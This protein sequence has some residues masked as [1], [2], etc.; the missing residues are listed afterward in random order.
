MTWVCT[1][2]VTKPLLMLT[3]NG[4]EQAYAACKFY[5][6]VVANPAQSLNRTYELELCPNFIQINCSYRHS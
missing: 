2:L 4:T 1:K 6:C 3:R 5:L